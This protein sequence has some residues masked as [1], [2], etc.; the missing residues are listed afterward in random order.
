MEQ[1]VVPQENSGGRIEL[2]ECRGE[3]GG[4]GVG[5]GAG[6]PNAGAQHWSCSQSGRDLRARGGYPSSALVPTSTLAFQALIFHMISLPPVLRLALALQTVCVTVPFSAGKT[7]TETCFITVDLMLSRMRCEFVCFFK[8]YFL[9][10]SK[11]SERFFV[12][13]V[14]IGCQL[15]SQNNGSWWAQVGCGVVP[16]SDRGRRCLLQNERCSAHSWSWLS[17]QSS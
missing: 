17:S 15:Q 11:G 6:R 16:L 7:L 10:C 9:L 8:I 2:W 3:K 13:D 14:F 12:F 4:G 5:G 1:Q